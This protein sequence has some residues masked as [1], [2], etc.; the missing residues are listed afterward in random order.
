MIYGKRILL[1]SPSFFGYEKEIK[2]KLEKMGAN[3]DFYDERP[4]NT[5]LG[6]ALVRINKNLVS[7]FIERHYSKIIKFVEGKKYDYFILIKGEAT[8]AFFLEKMRA[9][10]EHTK[11]IYYTYDSI[12]NNQN[13]LNNLA[14]F[15]TC[16][17]FDDNDAETI[18]S[19]QFRPLFYLDEYALI[20]NEDV[21]YDV[22][23][24]GTVHSD[25]YSLVKKVMK[26]I[27]DRQKKPL[28]SF[29]FFY[30]QSP[31]YYHLMRLLDKN[32]K[33]IKKADISFQP[34]HKSK[35]FEIFSSSNCIIDIHHPLQNGLTMR[36]IEAIGAKKKI[37][38]TN[39]SIKRYDIYNEDNIMVIDRNDP[40][41][42]HAFLQKPYS[43]LKEDVYERYSMERFLLDIL[44]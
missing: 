10:F 35:I 16:F 25:R 36:T 34:L 11:F 19:L 32:F 21:K 30:C 8:P 9:V 5:S 4:S 43:V 28:K 17:T 20:K 40:V 24:I 12:L 7:S 23:F 13:A 26:I 18:K 27:E 14:Y 6:K 22:S 44:A 29:L 33:E 31:W 38:T 3:V 39:N 1:I 2:R 37:I 15:D 41:V 42:D